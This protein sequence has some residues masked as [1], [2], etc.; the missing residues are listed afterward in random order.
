MAIETQSKR[1]PVTRQAI[2]DDL[3][4][5][6]SYYDAKFQNA[7]MELLDAAADKTGPRVTVAMV[8][9]AIGDMRYA[10]AELAAAVAPVALRR[11]EAVAAAL[12]GMT[13]VEPYEL[14]GWDQEPVRAFMRKLF[15]EAEIGERFKP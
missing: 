14:V 8:E 1:R 10:F 13:G 4:N 7:A 15:D 6:A 9:D 12:E 5:R 11:A 2:L 3:F